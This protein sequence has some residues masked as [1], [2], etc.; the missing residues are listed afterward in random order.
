MALSLTAW[1][2]QRSAAG[3]V[4]NV[5]ALVEA[6]AKMRFGTQEEGR[7]AARA[8]PA[9]Q[10][11]ARVAIGRLFPEPGLALEEG[12]SS[13]EKMRYRRCWGVP[14][15]KALEGASPQ[16]NLRLGVLLDPD[17]RPAAGE[18]ASDAAVMPKPAW[19]GPP[20]QSGYL[21]H[22]RRDCLDVTPA[23]TGPLPASSRARP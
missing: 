8:F 22:W 6:W 17:Y 7:W 23:S 3:A 14:V 5:Q 1:R 15:M 16:H 13:E 21:V 18:T 19:M 4:Q 10:E 11:N 20:G 12:H 9:L 2:W